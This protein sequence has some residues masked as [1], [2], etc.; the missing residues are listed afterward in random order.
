MVFLVRELVADPL[1]QRL[2]RAHLRLQIE[3]SGVEPRMPVLQTLVDFV[4]G[5]AVGLDGDAVGEHDGGAADGV[6]AVLRDAAARA[7]GVVRDDPADH[8]RVDG[9]GVR[10]DAPADAARAR[11]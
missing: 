7:R 9:R 10:P 8:G 5:V 1:R 4:G 11:D 2:V 6:I 3:E